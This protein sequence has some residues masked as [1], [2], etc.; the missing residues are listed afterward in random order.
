MTDVGE[1]TDT[2]KRYIS[3]SSHLVFESNYDD[4]MLQRDRRLEELDARTVFHALDAATALVDRAV[5]RARFGAGFNN[6]RCIA[7]CG[8]GVTGGTT[9]TA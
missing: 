6:W 4:T 5:R 1:A 7:L 8:G 3:L 2:V 9:L